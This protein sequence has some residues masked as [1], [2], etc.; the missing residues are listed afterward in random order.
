MPLRGARGG[1]DCSPA[2]SVSSGASWSSGCSVGGAVGG[3]GGG[4]G[5]VDLVVAGRRYTRARA[6]ADGSVRWTCATRGCPASLRTDAKGVVLLRRGA[7]HR[8]S[9]PP[10]PDRA[11]AAPLGLGA[12]SADEAAASDSDADGADNVPLSRRLQ[13]APTGPSGWPLLHPVN[14]YLTCGLCSGYLIDATTIVDCMHSFCR[15][16]IILHLR[17]NSFCPTCEQ[18]LRRFDPPL[19]GLR[20][21]HTLQTLVYK[22]VPELYRKERERRK[23]FGQQDPQQRR[24]PKPAKNIL[25]DEFKINISLQYDECVENEGG[26]G[27]GD[28]KKE[29]KEAKRY[30]NCPAAVRIKYLQ[31]FIRMKYGLSEAHRVDIIYNDECLPQNFTLKDVMYIFSLDKYKTVEFGFRIYLQDP[32]EQNVGAQNASSVQKKSR[33]QYKR[34]SAVKKKQPVAPTRSKLSRS[35]STP[36][37][38]VCIDSPEPSSIVP[39][40]SEEFDVTT[41]SKRGKGRGRGRRA[42][43]GTRKDKISFASLDDD[44]LRAGHLLEM[45]L[46]SIASTSNYQSNSVTECEDIN[47]QMTEKSASPERVTHQTG[48]S[49]KDNNGVSMPF[50]PVTFSED[51]TPTAEVGVAVAT[52]GDAFCVEENLRT[53]SESFKI[54]LGETQDSLGEVISDSGRERIPI[55]K[56][57]VA[58]PKHDSSY[59]S[60]TPHNEGAASQQTATHGKLVSTRRHSRTMMSP[61]R[62][63]SSK[64]NNS[65]VFDNRHS[66]QCSVREQFCDV[67]IVDNSVLTQGSQLS[68]VSG[69]RSSSMIGV[70][71]QK[72]GKSAT[73]D[74]KVDGNGQI[75]SNCQQNVNVLSSEKRDKIVKESKCP[76][77]ADYVP[78]SK[79][80]CVE[81]EQSLVLNENIGE[82]KDVLEGLE[83][84]DGNK[85]E[86]KK[87]ICT[88]E[89][90]STKFLKTADAVNASVNNYETERP[91]V[92]NGFRDM[93]QKV[94]NNMELISKHREQNFSGSSKQKAKMRYRN[95]VMKQR[96][97]QLKGTALFKTLEPLSSSLR[98]KCMVSKVYGLVGFKNM[99]C[100][101][102]RCRSKDTSRKDRKRR[103]MHS[104]LIKKFDID[105]GAATHSSGDI[106]NVVAVQSLDQ[107]KSELHDPS[108]LHR[109]NCKTCQNNQS[110][111]VI[112]KKVVTPSRKRRFSETCE[113]TDKE[114][115]IGGKVNGLAA[116]GVNADLSRETDAG[117]LKTVNNVNENEITD[118]TQDTNNCTDGSQADALSSSQNNCGTTSLTTNNTKEASSRSS[119]SIDNVDGTKVPNT[120]SRSGKTLQN[121]AINIQN[122]QTDHAPVITNPSKMATDSAVKNEL[123]QCKENSK[124]EPNMSS[125]ESTS[126]NKSSKAGDKD[127]NYSD[128]SSNYSEFDDFSEEDELILRVSEHEDDEVTSRVSDREDDEIMNENGV[129]SQELQKSANEEKIVADEPKNNSDEVSETSGSSEA[130]SKEGGQKFPEV[131]LPAGREMKDAERISK[132]KGKEPKSGQK[133]WSETNRP[134]K[135]ISHKTLSASHSVN[136]R[137]G[138]VV[139]PVNSSNSSHQQCAPKGNNSNPVIPQTVANKTDKKPKVGN[140]Y[141]LTIKPKENT[142]VPPPSITISRLNSNLKPKQRT[143]T[144]NSTKNK[145][146]SLEILPV[147]P[148]GAQHSA[149]TD[150]SKRISVGSPYFT[151]KRKPANLPLLKP[152]Q[153]LQ[154]IVSQAQNFPTETVTKNGLQIIPTSTKSEVVSSSSRKPVATTTNVS[155]NVNSKSSENTS[156]KNTRAGEAVLDLSEKST[157]YKVSS[158]ESLNQTPNEL[159]PPKSY[160]TAAQIAQNRASLCST[161][162]SNFQHFQHHFSANT[163]PQNVPQAGIASALG[164]AL[165]S[166]LRGTLTSSQAARGISNDGIHPAV[167]NPAFMVN[168]NTLSGASMQ[169]CNAKDE[170]EKSVKQQLYQNIQQKTKAAHTAAAAAA[171]A[172]AAS[173]QNV[174]SP[175]SQMM[176]GRNVRMQSGVHMGHVHTPSVCYPET[177]PTGPKEYPDPRSP[178]PLSPTTPASSPLSPTHQ[179]MANFGC[180]SPTYNPHPLYK[181]F[182]PASS[183]IAYDRA[184]RNLMPEHRNPGP[185]QTVRHIPNPSTLQ[186]RQQ[187]RNCSPSNAP[188]N[189]PSTSANNSLSSK[190]PF[191]HQRLLEASNSASKNVPATSTASAL[192]LNSGNFVSHDK[193]K[194]SRRNPANK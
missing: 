139:S 78:P 155:N 131:P 96:R 62:T 174:N 46:D 173:N 35:Q 31:H 158:P 56:S 27:G 182:T 118:K 142:I 104:V 181:T 48:A 41:K 149:A 187:R 37:V 20:R 143:D 138:N 33:R 3:V 128:K 29:D 190:M 22:M 71:E 145:R 193:T 97:M 99:N 146:P 163:P 194:P 80:L 14:P 189:V 117:S 144:S 77:A 135:V 84:T 165:S 177:S 61:P 36:N 81:Q 127:S 93:K 40:V 106:S 112:W 26:G 147:K 150:R 140:L 18:I 49:T 116:V 8:C 101:K 121:E 103:I 66:T 45:E 105:Y 136:N 98:R 44:M 108:P 172:A 13:P 42:R 180:L 53:P 91:E 132:E 153:L 170:T 43:S 23:T 168:R 75:L 111:S 63:T 156:N 171:A 114:H 120:H 72:G 47:Q 69:N 133:S 169:Y 129:Q 67:S 87:K 90:Q 73:A 28:I 1:R 17:S 60:C 148:S 82:G 24:I 52:K 59:N 9:L 151:P 70:T 4:A 6:N 19:H 178:I 119:L 166:A 125:K 34:K 65:D 76:V 185:S 176:Y 192:A 124:K 58:S 137:T 7:R 107:G 154:N 123:V 86:S 141:E 5:G 54:K 95:K 188:Q 15:S 25:T 186:F 115:V 92:N 11:A 30:L 159:Q 113:K 191:L 162:A 2:A 32:A 102:G 152:P 68:S 134:D 51:A 79:R 85:V 83:G 175:A 10:P 110:S 39:A 64:C 16:C 157:R 21:D 109:D 100:N 88:T 57:A 89:R 50:V 12:L 74:L 179:V 184:K 167:T 94:N 164:T 122:S 126:S 160:V 55:C 183:E 130:K 161:L 38:S